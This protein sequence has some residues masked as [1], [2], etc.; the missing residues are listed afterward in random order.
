MLNI[1][2]LLIMKILSIYKSGEDSIMNF[3]VPV[4]QPHWLSIHDLAW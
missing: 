4:N 2:N 3:Q 1:F